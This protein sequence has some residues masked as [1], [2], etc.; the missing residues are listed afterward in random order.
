MPSHSIMLVDDEPANRELASLALA[1]L[2][3]ADSILVAGN[4]EEAI[5]I[6]HRQLSLA[7]SPAVMLLDLDLPGR[8]GREVLAYSANHPGLKH[9]IIVILTTD[10]DPA[11]RERCVALGAAAYWIKPNSYDELVLLL[12]GLRRWLP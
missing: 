1:D 5:D 8:H 10:E 9:I 7:A 3:L 11:E 12:G 6:L 4:G 2:G